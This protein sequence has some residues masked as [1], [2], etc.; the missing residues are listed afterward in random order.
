MPR[1]SDDQGKQQESF[2]HLPHCVHSFPSG[3][4]IEKVHMGLVCTCLLFHLS[5][6][7]T[8]LNLSNC[9]LMEGAIL[10]DI[11]FL[12][13]LKILDLSINNFLSIP[14]S[15]NELTNLRDLRL[16]QYQNLIEIMGL[17]PSVQDINTNDCTSFLLGLELSISSSP[18][19]YK[20]MAISKIE[21]DEDLMVYS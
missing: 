8:N 15:L 13:S 6:H 20:K 18:M 1:G 21:F 5:T 2:N 4:Y 10:D 19:F 3:C 14:T 16:G 12:Y 17:P 11:C 9:N 7:F